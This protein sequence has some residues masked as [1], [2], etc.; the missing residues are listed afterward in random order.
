[1]LRSRTNRRIWLGVLLTAMAG[2]GSVQA[3]TE[4]FQHFPVTGSSYTSGSFTGRDGSTWSYLDCRGDKVIAAPSPCLKKGGP[5]Y[6]YVSSGIL[7]GGCG[8][9]SFQWKQA[10]TTAVN[11]D[12]LVNDVLRFTVT[13]GVQ[14]V[15][16]SVGP[17][18]ISQA[19]D[20]T[21]K[22][23][24]HDSNA[25][26]ITLDNITWTPYAGGGTHPP[27]LVM[28]PASTSVVM[29]A[30]N[31]VQIFFTASEPDG[32]ELHLGATGL[33]AGS[34]FAGSTGASPLTATFSW[35]PTPAR[36]GTYAIAFWARDKDGSVT[37]SLDLLVLTN[38]TYYYGT[39]GKGGANLRA[40][41][42]DIISSGHLQL[43]NTQEDAAMKDLD[44][45]PAN[46][47]NV[48]LLYRRISMA[49]SL[50]NDN[51][52][53]NKE[54]AWPES[55]G[56]GSSGP[57]QNDVHNLFAADKT[58][59]AL[60]GN[61]YFDESNP[62]EAGYV[63][64]AAT[65]APLTSRDTDSWEPPDEVKGDLARAVFYMDVRYDGL[66][67]DTLD[68]QVQDA[69][70]TTAEGRMGVLT[71]LLAWHAADPP[72]GWESN[73]NE[74]IYRSYQHNRNP[75][76]DHPEWVPALFDPR[77]LDSDADG[78]PDE[79]EQA[80]FNH[81]TN[82]VP[83]ADDDQDGM[84]N[85]DEYRAGTH[86]GNSNSVLKTS[87]EWNGFSF[88]CVVGSAAS[89]RVYTLE[90]GMDLLPDQPWQTAAT[91]NSR[92]G[93]VRFELAP[94]ATGRLYR[95]RAAPLP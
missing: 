6:P 42:H 58:V 32:D 56:L 51:Q 3:G 73:R 89:G 8:D 41:L 33:P 68:L 57:D 69:P 17:V 40:A 72:D 2:A 84:T 9:L 27:H 36:T 10:F 25:G 90:R 35:I 47:N 11:L 31:L 91:S 54:H 39:E 78:L 34:S 87:L 28:N 4:D 70:S 75:F 20:F 1:M 79:W 46:T 60:R 63:S 74:K 13:G 22:F 49:K 23:I 59:N 38:K 19:G 93:E 64:P 30:T 14:N 61:L 48:I 45:D 21:L 94:E 81:A 67:G 26:Q 50:Y 18:G 86:P 37:Q 92:S 88:R 80:H 52:G 43:D 66:E 76:V 83:A 53:W 12:V 95:V 77:H 29:A 85:L 44:T 55:R 71:T 82:A 16:N 15:T 65:N 62:A 24:Q 5:P 7:T